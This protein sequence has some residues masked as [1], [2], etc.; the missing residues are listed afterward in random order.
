MKTTRVR[1]VRRPFALLTVLGT[2]LLGGVCF[3]R[4]SQALPGA[5]GGAFLVTKFHGTDYLRSSFESAGKQFVTVRISG[6]TVAASGQAAVDFRVEDRA[7]APV[8]GITDAHFNIAK[9]SAPR[10]G[11]AFDRWVPYIYRLQ[12]VTEMPGSD[13]PNP[14]GTEAYQGYREAAADGNFID[15][16]DGRYRYEFRTNLTSARAGTRAITYERNLTHRI[17]VMLG[18]QSGQSGDAVYDFVPDGSRVTKTRD[19]VQTAI[20]QNCHGEFGLPGHDRERFQLGTCV[21]CHNP[22]QVDPHSGES[23][24][25]NVMIHKIH[26]GAH[27]DSI[28]GRDGIVFNNPSTPADESADNGRYAIWGDRNQKH[29]WWNIEVPGRH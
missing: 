28:P 19:I 23:L 2:L 27:L 22:G 13:W 26:A 21:T 18:G 10:D 16:G 14:S 5:D 24:D 1:F 8:A 29:T 25:M 15:F 12:T 20:C 6:A 4:M 9:L 3:A 7:G 17:A 11:E